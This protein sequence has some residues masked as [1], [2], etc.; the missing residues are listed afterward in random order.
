MEVVNQME[1][2]QPSSEIKLGAVLGRLMEISPV[3]KNAVPV[4]P[5]EVDTESAGGIVDN[6]R[7]S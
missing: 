6:G 3:E 7:S 2:L 5:T 1:E 4:P